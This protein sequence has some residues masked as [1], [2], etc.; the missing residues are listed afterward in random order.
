MIGLDIKTTSNNGVCKVTDRGSKDLPYL[1]TSL[2][3]WKLDASV[4]S[5]PEL[6]QE[7]HCA[8]KRAP[9]QLLPPPSSL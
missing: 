3:G 6:R 8:E 5:L 9:C 4:H 2:S 7:M 1:R